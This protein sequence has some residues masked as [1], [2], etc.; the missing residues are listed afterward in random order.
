MIYIPVRP[1]AMIR[2][3]VVEAPETGASMDHT[4]SHAA[5]ARAALVIAG[6]KPLDGRV[7]GSI[8]CDMQ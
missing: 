4:G 7:A 5:A 8:S 6:R 3:L 1:R 2:R